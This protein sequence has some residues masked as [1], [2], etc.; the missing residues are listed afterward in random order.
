M[1]YGKAPIALNLS[2][3]KDSRQMAVGSKCWITDYRTTD[4]QKILN[5]RAYTVLSNEC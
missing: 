1:A 3:E 4:K 5:R 2:R